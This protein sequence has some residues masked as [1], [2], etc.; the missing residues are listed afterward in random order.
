[1][2]T[3]GERIRFA[4]LLKGL[5]IRQL[6]ATVN[7]T[8]EALSLI[9]HGKIKPSLPRLRCFAETLESIIPYLGC[10][11]N[12]PENTLGQKITKARLSLGMEKIEFARIL[13]VNQRTLWGWERDLIKPDPKHLEKLQLFIHEKL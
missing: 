5:T 4:R 7:M 12:L 11:D 9:E 3:S 10:F 13:G 1:L 6:A 8:P 2:Y